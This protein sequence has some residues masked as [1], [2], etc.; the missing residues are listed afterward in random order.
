MFGAVFLFGIE[1]MGGGSSAPEPRWV[2]TRPLRIPRASWSPLADAAA[3]RL[4]SLETGGS[5][6]LGAPHLQFGFH[7]KYRTFPDLT[8]YVSL[9]ISARAGRGEAGNARPY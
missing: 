2:S 7:G 3:V 1:L 9:T 5:Q 4:I 8:N 6:V